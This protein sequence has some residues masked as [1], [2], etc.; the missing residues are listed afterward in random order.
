MVGALIAKLE[1]GLYALAWTLLGEL[2]VYLE[3]LLAPELALF[4]VIFPFDLPD[5]QVAERNIPGVGPVSAVPSK[6]EAF[7]AARKAA[8]ASG[9]AGHG[10]MTAAQKAA[11]KRALKS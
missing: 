5:V 6:K 2:R 7:T 9:W 1:R 8:L 3:T 10:K 11:F 4:R